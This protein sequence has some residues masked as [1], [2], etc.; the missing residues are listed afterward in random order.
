MKRIKAGLNYANLMGTVAV[1]IALGGSAYAVDRIDGSQIA[2]RSI[3][4]NKIE[5]NQIGPGE[6]NLRK[7]SGRIPRVRQA[8]DADSVG[9]VSPSQLVFGDSRFGYCNLKPGHGGDCAHVDVT[10]PDRPGGSRVMVLA[11]GEITNNNPGD[12]AVGSCFVAA[13]IGQLGSRRFDTADAVDQLTITAMSPEL[14]PGQHTLTINCSNL[15][16]DYFIA[17]QVSAIV[18]GTGNEG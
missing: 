3:S 12:R 7:V 14:S 2:N 9:G 15:G 10:V 5:R 16:G 13:E 17:T 8:A 18:M 6:I 1:F 11:S 4:A